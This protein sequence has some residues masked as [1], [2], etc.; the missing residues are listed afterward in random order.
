[1]WGSGPH[2]LAKISPHF[3]H[4]NMGETSCVEYPDG[5]VTL[6]SVGQN[7]ARLAELGVL[8]AL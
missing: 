1:M 2:T 8:G 4:K 6:T 5:K 7:L 3:W